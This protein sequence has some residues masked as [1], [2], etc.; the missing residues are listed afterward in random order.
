MTD[1]EK[2]KSRPE[3]QGI[4]LGCKILGWVYILDALSIIFENADDPAGF[5]N[6]FKTAVCFIMITSATLMLLGR[7]IGLAVF[8]IVLVIGGVSILSAHYIRTAA[9]PFRNVIVTMFFYFIPTI[10]LLSQWNAFSPID[11]SHVGQ[12]DSVRAIS[13]DGAFAVKSSPGINEG[14]ARDNLIQLIK[15]LLAA[16]N[17]STK[18]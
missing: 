5:I 11:S 14:T 12:N 3:T 16:R 18:R 15:K 9:I 2:H 4:P 13:R 7:K 8:S 17:T 10:Y 1:Q 6:M